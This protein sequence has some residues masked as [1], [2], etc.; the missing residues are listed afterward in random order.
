MADA[1]AIG[2]NNSQSYNANNVAAFSGAAVALTRL[3]AHMRY[4][5]TW[6]L[7]YRG[8]TN[9]PVTGTLSG[10]VKVNGVAVPD[11]WVRVYYRPNGLEA[12]VGRTDTNGAFSFT[13]LDPGAKYFVVAFDDLNIAP[14]RN[15]QVFDLLAPV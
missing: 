14:D 9:I 15:A 5:P 1:G 12:R 11:Y 10:T 4:L 13:D 7:D 3:S 2:T 8:L 6:A